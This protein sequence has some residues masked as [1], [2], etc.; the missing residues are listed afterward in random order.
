MIVVIAFV[1]LGVAACVSVIIFCG[2]KQRSPNILNTNALS[3]NP[4]FDPPRR[5]RE[6][7][8]VQIL[9]AQ[10]GRPVLGLPL[11]QIPLKELYEWQ[12]NRKMGGDGSSMSPAGSP[13]LPT[14]DREMS[15]RGV[16]TGQQ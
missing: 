5:E 16:G 4:D 3:G 6:V 13:V 10:K 12:Q 8:Q 15:F 2:C 9:A 14:E 11:K 7:I 1:V